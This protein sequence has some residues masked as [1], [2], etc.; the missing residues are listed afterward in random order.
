MIKTY[1]DFKKGSHQNFT[2][3]KKLLLELNLKLYLNL[4][5]NEILVPHNFA[6]KT[7]T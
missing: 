4:M 7:F 6:N 1:L 2:I 5:L 3:K